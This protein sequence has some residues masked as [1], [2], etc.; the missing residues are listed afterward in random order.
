MTEIVIALKKKAIWRRIHWRN[1]ITVFTIAAVVA[2]FLLW[3]I[4]LHNYEIKYIK[5][6]VKKDDSLIEIV[7]QMN[8]YTPWGWDSRDFVDLTMKKNQIVNPSSI[9]PGDILLIP[10]AQKKGQ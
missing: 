6:E 1:V 3:A 10:V 9:Q 8:D 4:S 5:Y 2:V 7:R